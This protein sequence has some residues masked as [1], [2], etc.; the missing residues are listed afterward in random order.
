M[1]G[2]CVCVNGAVFIMYVR[3]SWFDSKNMDDEWE[4]NVK[5]GLSVFG[6]TGS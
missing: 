3:P 1:F 4:M 5:T 2:V 6:L